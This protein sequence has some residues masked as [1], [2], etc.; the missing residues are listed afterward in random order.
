LQCVTEV[1]DQAWTVMQCNT[2]LTYHFF[3][4]GKRLP[5]T[6]WFIQEEWAGVGE[7]NARMGKLGNWYKIL[8]R[9]HQAIA[10]MER[11]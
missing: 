8:V 1:K 9:K 4:F 10:C 7:G 11:W 3:L 5:L 6:R 2:F